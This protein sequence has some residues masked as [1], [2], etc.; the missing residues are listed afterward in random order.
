MPGT[1]RCIKCSSCVRACPVVAEIGETTFPGPRKVLWT[2]RGSALPAP[3]SE[4]WPGSA[5]CASIAQRPALPAY[6]FPKR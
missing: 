6:R 1:D 3:P 2:N 5:P 4:K